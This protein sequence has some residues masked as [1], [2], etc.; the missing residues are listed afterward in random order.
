MVNGIEFLSTRRLSQDCLENVF[1]F[2]R[3]KVGF[4]DNPGPKRFRDT[5]KQTMVSSLLNL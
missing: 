2:I 1:S 3:G 5:I 4:R